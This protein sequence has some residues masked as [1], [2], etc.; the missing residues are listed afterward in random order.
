MHWRSVIVAVAI[1]TACSL[2]AHAQTTVGG[3]FSKL[4]DRSSQPAQ[5]NPKNYDAVFLVATWCPVSEELVK[6]LR[7]RIAKGALPDT[8]F[9]FVV[10]DEWAKYEEAAPSEGWSP[11]D[12]KNIRKQLETKKKFPVILAEPEAISTYPGD[13]F[14]YRG[15][16]KDIKD[17]GYPSAYIRQ[18]D[19]FSVHAADALEMLGIPLEE[20]AAF[21]DGDEIVGSN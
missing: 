10:T 3:A 13:V 7:A 12:L 14:F 18:V 4:V 19:R 17:I 20:M 16:A 1:A 6:I 8:S 2:P 5:L 9:A 11:T 15:A 21:Y